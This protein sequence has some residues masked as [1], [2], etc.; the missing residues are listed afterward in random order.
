MP[1]KLR[2]ALSDIA[3]KSIKKKGYYA[4]GENLYL[5]VTASTTK[6]WMLRYS[7]NGKQREMGLGAYPLITL[8]DARIVATANMRLIKIDGI[9]PIEK[10]KN[11][12]QKALIEKVRQVTFAEAALSYIESHRSGWK[13]SKHADQW[14]NTLRDYAYPIFEKL[15]I[16][17]I[18]TAMVMK[19]IE[20]IWLTKTETASRTR[21]RIESILDW[22]TT[23]GYRDGLNPARWKGHL[24]NLLP[25]RS[26]VT[27]VKHHAALPVNEVGEFMAE[28]RSQN[29]TSALALEFCILTACRTGEVIGAKWNE[30]DL[31]NNIWVIPAERMKAKKEHRVPLS[32]RALD[33]LKNQEQYNRSE[34]IF[35]GRK[36]GASLSNMAMLELLKRMERHDLTVHGFRSTFSD[37]A[38]ENT[39]FST[40]VR[41]ASLAHTI[42]DKVEAAYRRGDLFLK[43]Q[44]LMGQW[45]DFCQ[46]LPLS[47][48]TAIHTNVV[49]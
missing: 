14:A 5:R 29:G 2:H 39:N 11:E 21:G 8:A 30:V 41:E 9:D 34:Y 1:K 38:S 25:A 19:V 49:R 40:E 10:K 3:V 26:K 16:A 46:N 33:I 45:A 7:M 23:R 44:K 6:S 36:H 48:V 35:T 27:K 15:P 24:E 18:D 47:N 20:P 31:K 42:S 22:A 4:D 37:W 13:N 32:P 28:L 17:S 43:R 12:Q